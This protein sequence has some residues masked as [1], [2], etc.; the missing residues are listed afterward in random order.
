MA[1]FE[2]LY[3]KANSIKRWWITRSKPLYYFWLYGAAWWTPDSLLT[4][5]QKLVL[6]FKYA[7]KP[8][9]QDAQN[10]ALDKVCN[11]LEENFPSKDYI[12]AFVPA[13]TRIW[14]NL[15]FWNFSKRLS[16]RLWI[17]NWF[18]YIQIFKDRE[19]KHSWDRS[20]RF[21]DYITV[22]KDFKD[23]NIIIFDDLVTSWKNIYALRNWLSSDAI[24]WHPFLALTLWRTIKWGMSQYLLY[25]PWKKEEEKV[26]VVESIPIEE[27][28]KIRDE[29]DDTQTL[30]QYLKSIDMYPGSRKEWREKYL[31]D[32]TFRLLARYKPLNTDEFEKIDDFSSAHMLKEL[33]WIVKYVRQYYEQKYNLLVKK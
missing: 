14:N 13:S 26:S 10:E 32:D 25:E 2:A 11:F 27:L 17:E 22:S 8:W 28:K 18:D 23:K 4:P 20:I 21:S 5:T 31:I 33:G 15:R 19:A 16:E 24:K 1:S 7:S 12:F 3:E 6:N 29:D 9:F 30:Y